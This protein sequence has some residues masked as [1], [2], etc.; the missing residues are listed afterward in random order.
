MEIWK[1]I[2]GYEGR[3]Q[4]SDAGNVRSLSRTVNYG[5]GHKSV[6]GA[7]FQNGRTLRPGRSSNGHFTVTL[8]KTRKYTVH[9]LVLMTFVGPCPPKHVCFHVTGDP[10]DNR[11]SNLR[12]A[13]RSYVMRCAEVAH[14]P[15]VLTPARLTGLRKA[16]R[17]RRQRHVRPLV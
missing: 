10:A 2:P 13:T 9:K 11:L 8:G 12:W 5:T 4:V 14:G 7:R 3:Y 15:W 17:T 16:A 6:A 1:D